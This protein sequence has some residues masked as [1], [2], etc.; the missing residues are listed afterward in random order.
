VE[1]R[2]RRGGDAVVE[3][4]PCAL[5]V[6]VV[7]V[8]VEVVEVVVVAV[9]LVVVVVVAITAL[10]ATKFETASRASMSTALGVSASGTSVVVNRNGELSPRPLN[11][12][13]CC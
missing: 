11:W 5:V 7:V 2:R 9:V 12:N 6:V 4:L 10:V 3:L 13:S 1:E 8:V